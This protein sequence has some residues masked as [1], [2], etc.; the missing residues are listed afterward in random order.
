MKLRRIPILAVILMMMSFVTPIVAN[1]DSIYIESQDIY[2]NLKETP[3]KTVVV[4]KRGVLSDEQ[5]QQIEAAGTRLRVYDV[6]LYVEMTERSTCSQSYANTLAEQ[7]FDELMPRK[8]NSVMIIFTFYED[9]GGYYAVHYNVQGNLSENQV[10]QKIRGT[11]HEFKTDATWIAGSFEQVIDYLT[12]VE[13][14]LINADQI[15]EQQKENLILIGKIFRVILELLAIVVIIYLV[16]EQ[17]RNDKEFNQTIN[18]KNEKIELLHEEARKKKEKCKEL[19][20][21]CKELHKWKNAA[22]ASTPEV[23]KNISTFY[24]R[25]RAK[26]FDE[27]FRNAS[28]FDELVQM[29]SEY[30]EMSS[31]EKSFVRLDVRKAR[32]E[33]EKMAKKEAEK[34]TKVITEACKET[35]NRYNRDMFDHTMGYYNGLPSCVKILIAAHLIRTLNDKHSAAQSDYKRY[36]SSSSSHSHSHS[37]SSFHHAGGFHSGTF[38]GG[39][40][41]GH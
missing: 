10:N 5:I 9:A 37:S 29:V 11:Y 3:T 6:G 24:A 28:S 32:S 41:G 4:D 38:G 22:I 36:H 39:F 25:Q 26:E 40:H 2:V 21:T 35:G 34:A 15:A 20:K 33:M 27:T 16:R 30:D 12:E 14:N 19:D 7:K 8:E 23:E 1:A 13:N 17:R 18:K 31:E